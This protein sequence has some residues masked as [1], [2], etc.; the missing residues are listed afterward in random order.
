[1]SF[2]RGHIELSGMVWSCSCHLKKSIHDDLTKCVINK[3][4]YN[5]YFETSSDWHI[6]HS[7]NQMQ[8]TL[9]MWQLT[10]NGRARWA[11]GGGTSHYGWCNRYHSGGGNRSSVAVDTGTDWLICDDNA[12]FSVSTEMK[13][14]F[15]STCTL[16]LWLEEC[17]PAQ[18][19]SLSSVYQR[20]LH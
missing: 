10:T 6:H 16:C 5:N 7:T 2:F 11:R 4:K 20:Q 8:L 3:E 12:T 1:M 19:L 15:C 13:Y 17:K 9:V 18:H 14:I